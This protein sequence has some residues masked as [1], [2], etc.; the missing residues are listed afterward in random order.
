MT[1]TSQ[2]SR[3]AL[4]DGLPDTPVVAI[5]R[6]LDFD[7]ARRAGEG[8]AEGGIKVV[9][10]TMD[11]PDLLGYFA[12]LQDELPSLTLGV[13][14]VLS[15]DGAELAIDA[16][17]RFLVC[18]HVNPDIIR[19]AAARGVPVFPGA[20]TATEV[21]TAWEAGAAA[22]KLFPAKILK[23]DTVRALREPLPHIPLVAVGGIDDGNAR[24][25]MDA[26][27]VAVGVGA[28]LTGTGDTKETAR[29]AARLTASI[30]N[31][32]PA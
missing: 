18:P 12:R 14:S 32:R 19:F 4:P 3:P 29:R 8:I 20:A 9:E 10:V 23:P 7:Q 25:F 27:A 1:Q 5:L 11:S 13:G 24:S 30:A 26:G 15:V 2:P 6:R 21:V 22:V 17:A 31:G 16:A 28:W